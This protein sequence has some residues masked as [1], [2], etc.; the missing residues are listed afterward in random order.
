LQR[1]S[2]HAYILLTPAIHGSNLT[3][4]D[5]ANVNGANW[6]SVFC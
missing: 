1:E 4:V 6:F 5:H 2:F 3:I